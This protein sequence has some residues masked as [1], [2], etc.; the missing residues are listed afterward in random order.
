MGFLPN[1]T[2]TVNGLV[3]G[4]TITNHLSLRIQDSPEISCGWDWIPYYHSREEFGILGYNHILTITNWDDP[5]SILQILKRDQLNGPHVPNP[6][7]SLRW[8]FSAGNPPRRFISSTFPFGKGT[9]A[10]T[11]YGTWRYLANQQTFH[12][13]GPY[14]LQVM[15]LL[16]PLLGLI[17]TSVTLFFFGNL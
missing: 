1:A 2:P 6:L 11:H 16:T 8:P 17:F 12:E 3:N 13:V 14:H 10:I 7:T 9:L 5:P 4:G 15:G